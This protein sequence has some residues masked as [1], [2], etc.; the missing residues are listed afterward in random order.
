MHTLSYRFFEE[1]DEEVTNKLVVNNRNIITEL[2]E[3][4]TREGI[5]KTPE[6]TSKAIQFLTYGYCQDPAEIL[7]SALFAEDYH[8]MVII[9][10]IEL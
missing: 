7:K 8:N 1:Y 2:G 3:D 9:R 10:D 5:V 6:R 4:V